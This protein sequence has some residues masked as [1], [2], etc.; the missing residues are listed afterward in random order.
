MTYLSNMFFFG[1]K[2][3]KLNHNRPTQ[4]KSYLFLQGLLHLKIGK[5]FVN[6]TFLKFVQ[7]I[8]EYRD[9]RTNN[10][11]GCVQRGLALAFSGQRS[12]LLE[13]YQ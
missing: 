10:V 4:Q 2:V 13:R 5:V 7:P 1:T 6:L 12:L 3:T 8:I 9:M 11:N